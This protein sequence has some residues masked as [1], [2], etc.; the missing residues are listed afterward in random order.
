MKALS[1]DLKRWAPGIEILSVRVTKPTIP[2]KILQNV[3][4]MEKVKVQ[5]LIAV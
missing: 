3:E 1:L 4:E 5:Y 2:K